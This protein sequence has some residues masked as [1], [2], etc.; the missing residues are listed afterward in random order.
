MTPSDLKTAEIETAPDMGEDVLPTE[1]E[2]AHPSSPIKNDTDE[3][4]LERFRSG[5][6]LVR[7][8]IYIIGGVYLAGITYNVVMAYQNHPSLMDIKEFSLEVIRLLI[9]PLTFILGFMFGAKEK[10]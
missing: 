7:T 3:V 1:F 4:A 8:V 9:P 6:A 10:E 2:V 5:Y